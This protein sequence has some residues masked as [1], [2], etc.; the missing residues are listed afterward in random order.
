MK[1]P[2]ASPHSARLCGSDRSLVLTKIWVLVSA[3]CTFSGWVL[4]ALGHLDLA[5]Y[6]A[7]FFLGYVIFFLSVRGK[8]LVDQCRP[9]H[10]FK[11]LQKR[12]RRALPFVFL[13]TAI[14][15]FVGGALYTPNNYDALTY[16]F[17]RI[18]HWLAE[19][20]WHWID[21]PNNRMNYS[22]TGFEWLMVPLFVFSGGDR[23]FFLINV[24]SQLLL[25]GLVFSCF[26]TLGVS[27]Q[28]AWQ[29]MWLLPL[30][31]CFALQS[32]SIGNDTF[33]AV[34]LLAAVVFARRAAQRNSIQDLWIACLAAALTTG[35]KA[36]NLPLLLPISIAAF[37]A[38]SLLKNRV[39]GSLLVAVVA[40]SI[41]F[42]PVGALNQMHSGDWTGD[43]LNNGK[44]K[45]PNPATGLI[46]NGLQI[47]AGNMQPSICPVAQAWNKMSERVLAMPAMRGVVRDY[48][49]L[50]FQWGELAIEEG[51]GIGAG[52]GLLFV[53]SLIYAACKWKRGAMDF[54]AKSGT[55]I[56][57]GGVA[58]LLVY[59]AKI[60][61][62]SAPRL[63]AAYYPLLLAIPLL[64]PSVGVLVRKRW[65]KIAVLLV[66]LSAVP[67]VI[68]TPSRPLWPA[69]TALKNLASLHPENR[70]ISRAADVYDVYADRA[71]L[72]APLKTHLPA[73]A[74]IIGF[75]SGHDNPEVSLWRPFGSRRVV[76]ISA[77][78]QIGVGRQPIRVMVA[79]TT[80]MN[81]VFG[82]TAEA[83]ARECGGSILGS[84][85]IR[86]KAAWGDEEWFVIELKK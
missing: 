60:G 8:N 31:Y 62:E 13:L 55:W 32:G 67:A 1:P 80:A 10:S 54:S 65:W 75:V 7:S 9:D 6:S 39:A 45:L 76:E 41:S 42:L 25:P 14:L 38:F 35:A 18:L 44:M 4:S 50:G 59:M 48:P 21:A 61:S 11:K 20:R 5:G 70:M 33:A 43:P 84:E 17:P 52:L 29:W 22:G 27:R 3:W 78:Q 66:A 40:V 58:A 72:F 24:A 16:R 47:V 68:L 56:V 37:P 74:A 53:F 71:D 69:R 49:R 46:G 12:F 63:V 83:F 86:M 81:A 34:Y 2:Q 23:L 79:S 77:P 19:G 73:D 82:K 28:A 26:T 30:G 85:K 36:S 15:A 51:A 57:V 64:N